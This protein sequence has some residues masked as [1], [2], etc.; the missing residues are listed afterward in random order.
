MDPIL[1]NND[2]NPINIKLLKEITN[3]S[4]SDWIFENTFLIFN[5]I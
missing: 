3:N 5:S 4:Y 2:F 1:K